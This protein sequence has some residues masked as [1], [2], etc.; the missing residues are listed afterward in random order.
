MKTKFLILTLCLSAMSLFT[1]ELF[2][3]EDKK[4]NKDSLD[5]QVQMQKEQDSDRMATLKNE[6]KESKED[7]KET[8]RVNKEA[9]TAARE[10]S[11]ALKAEKKA[12]RSRKMADDQAVKAE[13]ARSKSDS[14]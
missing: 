6:K 7:A 5:T 10:S 2:S 3:Q 12:Q 8:K 11:S 13:K 9:N 1:V 14:N 4:L